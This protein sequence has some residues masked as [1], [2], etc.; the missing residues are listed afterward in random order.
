MVL[1][2][3]SCVLVGGLPNTA[4]QLKAE[5]DQWA[6]LDVAAVAEPELQWLILM[7]KPQLFNAGWDEDVDDTPLA[8]KTAWVALLGEMHEVHDS[9]PAAESKGEEQGG[10]AGLAEVQQL[11][12]ELLKSQEERDAAV[13]QLRKRRRREDGARGRL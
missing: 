6:A 7:S 9:G 8:I 1:P 10:D 2:Q 12:A 5:R 13:R 11:Q 3:V 4:E